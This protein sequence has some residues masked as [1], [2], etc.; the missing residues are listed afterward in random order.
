MPV[1]VAMPG[2][3]DTERAL[4]FIEDAYRSRL[5]RDGRSVEHPIAVSQLLREDGQPSDLVLAGLLHDVLE[6]TEVAPAE[7]REQFGPEVTRLVEALTQ[8]ESIPKHRAR[9]SALR[10]Q[11]LDAGPEA[12]TVALADKAA[13][14]AS[15]RE[16]PKERRLDHYRQTL[17]GV[18]QRYGPSRLS[19]RLRE[20][21]ARFPDGANGSKPR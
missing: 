19:E 16:R 9:K 13:K 6:D 20:E 18:E 15:E 10:Q 2:S 17:T 14:L 8:D 11:V 1:D 7:L 3:P 5:R 21:L 12:A 4:S